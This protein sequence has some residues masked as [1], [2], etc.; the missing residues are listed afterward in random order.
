[1][2]RRG[3]VERRLQIVAQRRGERG[4]VAGL[5]LHR[6][7]QRRPQILAFADAA[8]R[9]APWLRRRGAA[10][11]RSASSSGPRVLGFGAFGLGKRFARASAAVRAVSASARAA[12]GGVFGG[13]HVGRFGRVLHG[14][15]RDGPALRASCWPLVSANA[16]REFARAFLARLARVAIRRVRRSAVPACVR[17]RRA[18]RSARRRRVSASASSSPR[19]CDA[20]LRARRLRRRA[21]RARLAGVVVERAFAFDVLLGLGDAL[22]QRCAA[23][24][25]R[26][27]SASSASRSTTR[28]CSAA[29]RSAS[30]WRSGGKRGRGVG[31][32]GRGFAP[33][34]RCRSRRAAAAA[35][36]S[37]SRRAHAQLG[38]GPAQIMRQRLGL[39]DMAGEI[40]IARGLARLAL[41]VLA[42]G[43]RLRGSRRRGGRDWFRRRAG[44]VRPR[45]GADA[46]RR[47]RRLLPGWRGAPAASG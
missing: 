22:A 43:L 42:A 2:M 26:A 14:A 25:A 7:D 11:S 40:A 12:V 9:R 23:S 13:A 33:R 36:S 34:A 18:L 45:D 19:A 4:F 38:G 31:L 24:R 6:I 21:R 32:R 44:A 39:A 5:H 16:R 20:P 30:I 35:A 8:D 27:S 37:S 47:C 29:E 28:R 41:Q 10:T 17:L 15:R 3:F 1:M 46:G